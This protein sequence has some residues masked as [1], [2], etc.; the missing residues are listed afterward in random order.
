MWRGSDMGVEQVIFHNVRRERSSFIHMPT[1][2]NLDYASREIRSRDNA[3]YIIKCL[4][5][6][7]HSYV[8]T[9]ISAEVKS[10]GRLLP[11]NSIFLEYN[12]RTKTNEVCLS[13]SGSQFAV[14][15]FLMHGQRRAFDRDLDWEPDSSP[16]PLKAPGR[17]GPATPS[18]PPPSPPNQ[19]V[20]RTAL[21][22]MD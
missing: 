18:R 16:G 3:C 17:G 22:A 21:A 2:P 7:Y 12:Q 10:D 4:L 15:Q 20:V 13:V 11:S 6:Q 1:P 8:S 5:V 14:S 9:C 19:K